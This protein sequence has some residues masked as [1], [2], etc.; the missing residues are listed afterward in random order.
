MR[1]SSDLRTSARNAALVAPWTVVPIIALALKGGPHLSRFELI[2]S[3]F[4]VGV[5]LAVPLTYLAVLIAGYPTYKILL[6]YHRLNACTLTSAG[7]IVGAAFGLVFVGTEAAILCGFCG[8]AVSLTAWLMIRREVSQLAS[9]G[10]G[11]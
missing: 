4:F 5:L 11:V 9:G 2:A 6:R 1:A 7:A 3:G 8:L 10:K